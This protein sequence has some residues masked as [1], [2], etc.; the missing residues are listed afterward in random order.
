MITTH[1][2]FSK[3]SLVDFT[4]GYAGLPNSPEQWGRR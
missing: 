2:R 3:G 1:F 4:K